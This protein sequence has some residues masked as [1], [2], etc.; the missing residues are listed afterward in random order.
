MTKRFKYA[1]LDDKDGPKK[2]LRAKLSEGGFFDNTG[3]G[4]EYIELG[5]WSDYP[6]VMHELSD[7][8]NTFFRNIPEILFVDLHWENANQNLQ[9]KAGWLIWTMIV[10]TPECKNINVVLY[11]GHG[12]LIGDYDV[13][14]AR[15]PILQEDRSRFITP[16][17]LK[18][19]QNDAFEGSELY[20]YL[21][22]ILKS[23]RAR[24]LKSDIT[25][26][27]EIIKKIR[28]ESAQENPQVF[29]D[30][31]CFVSGFKITDFF[32]P[33][34]LCFE[35]HSNNFEKI[36]EELSDI[37]K[38]LNL[39]DFSGSLLRIRTNEV[40]VKDCFHSLK[41]LNDTGNSRYLY[42]EMFNANVD[43]NIVV[44]FLE[45]LDNS[46]C[47]YFNSK[48]I[49]DLLS[50]NTLSEDEWEELICNFVGFWEPP[51][52]QKVIKPTE[53]NESCQVQPFFGDDKSSV[54]LPPM[55]VRK[56]FKILIDNTV[57]YSSSKQCCLGYKAPNN[58]PIIYYWDQ[59]KWDK[60]DKEIVSAFSQS[61][62]TSGSD[63]AALSQL[64]SLMDGK[65]DLTVELR[66]GK[67]M[68]FKNIVGLI[69]ES[70]PGSFGDN[71]LY[72]EI[73]FNYTN[74]TLF[75]IRF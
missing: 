43:R 4:L 20:D 66:N 13:F 75:I 12:K 38:G 46:I 33:Y 22:R 6:T 42:S 36:L 44:G 37:E 48:R 72:S 2:G 69:E 9:E 24:I 56:I 8:T 30:Q 67:K 19:G 32:I 35:K 18:K 63:L 26:L 57:A 49:I 21:E 41:S 52:A 25:S 10:S 58:R 65:I 71:T 39:V 70:K 34:S 51:F 61:G 16:Y 14:T 73:D 60:T 40:S 47:E 1:I 45:G 17:I 27:K 29:L 5:G 23:L 55:A 62:S 59:G 50:K 31:S 15:N 68:E 7:K 54:Y 53:I 11:T 64:V 3:A 28:Q 74:G